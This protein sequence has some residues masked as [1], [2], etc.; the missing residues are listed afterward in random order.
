[1]KE[2]DWTNY[3]KKRKSYISSITQ[4]ITI[5]YLIKVLTKCGMR[6]Q[7][8]VM[9]LGGGR[10][11]FAT[12]ISNALPVEFYDVIDKCQYAVKMAG[13]NRVI[14]NALCLDLTKNM[15]SDVVKDNYNLVYSVGLVEHFSNLD[16]RCVIKNHFNLC[17]HGGYVLITAPTLTLKYM[18]I[19]KCMEVLHLWQFWDE[20]PLNVKTLMKEMGNYG[21]IV[22]AGINRKLPLTQCVV[23]AKKVNIYAGKRI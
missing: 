17:E 6:D 18:I 9:E 4:R 19:R 22:H 16:R 7:W 1:M 8:R 3:Y 21:E 14:R 15:D 20:R 12:D 10:S 2:T 13:G 23:V 5:G 11:C